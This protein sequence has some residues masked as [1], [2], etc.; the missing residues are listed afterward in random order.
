MAPDGTLRLRPSA[1]AGFKAGIPKALFA[2]P[3]HVGD[4][5]ADI[6]FRWDVAVRGDRFLIDTAATVSEPVTIVRNWT[7]SMKK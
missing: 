6:A 4:E 1:L 5:S 2:A 3:I 7:A